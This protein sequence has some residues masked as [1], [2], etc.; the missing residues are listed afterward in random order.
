MHVH[1][2][3]DENNNNNNK[4]NN[5]QGGTQRLGLLHGLDSKMLFAYSDVCFY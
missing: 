2:R 3:E 1:K 5:M 4:V